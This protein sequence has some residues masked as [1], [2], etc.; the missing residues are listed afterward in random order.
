MDRTAVFD[1]HRSLL[2]S[3]AYRMLG[4]SSD[5][6]DVVQEAYLRWQGAAADEVASPKAY[7]STVVTRLA[8][9]S[10]RS[11]RAQ[12]EQYLGPW[13]PEPLVEEAAPSPAEQLV[14][15]ES[16]S[17]AFL[18]VL[19]Q[20]GP[21]ERAVFLL[22]EVFD[23]DYDDVA[24]IVGKT[25]EHC[26]QV[27]H[28]ARE[29]VRAARPRRAVA[30]DEQE[31]LTQRFLATLVTGDVP[32]LAEL[33]AAD[34]VLYSDGGG[35]TAAARKPV[36]GRDRVARFFAGIWRKMPPDVVARI[37]HVNGQPGGVSYLGGRPYSVLVFDV[38]D[39]AIAAV[40]VVVNP[41]KLRHVPP[42]Q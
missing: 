37:V 18:V 6:E 2:F 22:R 21:V 12:R 13:L 39:G 19:E 14:L 36:R 11:A 8:I 4:S 31:R 15:A 5:A 35:K 33:L 42:L 1:A 25:P 28:R 3:I 17:M 16:L 27:L 34:V 26:R 30:A 10:L 29:R 23:Y 9:D 20:L 40:R 38:A 41:D 7:L 32:A 24:R